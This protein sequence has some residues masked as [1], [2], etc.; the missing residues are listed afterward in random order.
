VLPGRF[1]SHDSLVEGVRGARLRGY[2]LW[3][4]IPS[5]TAFWSAVTSA[6]I[7]D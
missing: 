1:L 7:H 2:K 4:E 5:A 3:V 6:S